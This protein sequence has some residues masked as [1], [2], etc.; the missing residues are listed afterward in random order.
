M[1]DFAD[2]ACDA[3]Q[4]AIDLAYTTAKNLGDSA[5]DSLSSIDLSLIFFY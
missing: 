3:A 5:L 4:S 1:S 2:Y